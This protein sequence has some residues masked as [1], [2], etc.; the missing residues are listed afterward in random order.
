MTY[1]EAAVLDALRRLPRGTRVAQQSLLDQTRLPADRLKQALSG[2]EAS[3]HVWLMG[4]K[5]RL[6]S[7]G[8][9]FDT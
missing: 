2:L 4:D 8:T 1:D 7:D 9:T 6:P 3:G 5:V